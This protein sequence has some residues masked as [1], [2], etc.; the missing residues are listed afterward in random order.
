M[1]DAQELTDGRATRLDA[2]GLRA[3]REDLLRMP[4]PADDSQ[5]LEQIEELE[6]TKAA[7]AALQASTTSVVAGRRRS[8]LETQRAEARAAGKRGF[9]HI[10]ASIGAEIGLARHESPTQGRTHL[11]LAD[12]LTHDLP[13]TLAAL[14]LGDINEERALIIARETADLSAED[15]RTVDAEL[16]ADPHYDD[17][18]ALGDHQL[19]DLL[20]RIVYRIDADGTA[21]RWARAR[22]RR[23]VTTRNLGDGT[24][25]ITTIVAIEHAAT[26][27]AAL[28]TAADAAHNTGDPRTRDQIKADTVVARI[29]GQTSTSTST[30]TVPNPDRDPTPVTV[31]L[32]ISA[33]S[34][35]G[36]SNEPGHLPGTG[37]IP[38][39]FAR[40]WVLRATAQARAALRRLFTTP[41]DRELV[42]M[43]SRSRAFPTALAE[44]IDLRDAGTCRTPWCNAPIRHHDHAVPVADG[45]TTTLDNGQGLC[46]AC[47]YVKE[48]PDWITWITITP[49]GRHEVG[50]LTPSHHTYTTRPPPQPGEPRTRSPL[51]GEFYLPEHLTLQVDY[52]A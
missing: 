18:T 27:Q 17:T 33:E 51:R 37:A 44:L 26:I 19:R 36:D 23:R 10:E 21:E 40:S 42:A 1:S 9:G 35:L 47:N 39:A 34:L 50:T 6:R 45:G 25:R 28:D 31:N 30:S 13:C 24:A 4:V 14:F 8:T 16:F 38:A 3:L 41:T 49:T 11:E 46:E 29:T 48:T 7:I 22:A 43:E 12:A 52:A 32:V 5:A 15:R 20:R 2:A